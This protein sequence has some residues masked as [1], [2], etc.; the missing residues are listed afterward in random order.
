MLINYKDVENIK[1]NNTVEEYKKS[2]GDENYKLFAYLANEITN[3]T[4]IDITTDKLSSGAFANNINNK[5]YMFDILN[6]ISDNEK[7][8]LWPNNNVIYSNE[9]ITDD[10]IRDKFKDLILNSSII[11]IDYHPHNGIFEYNFYQWLKENNYKGLLIFDDIHYFKEMR[12]NLWHKIPSSEKYDVT[13]FG[14]WSGTGLV[15][16]NGQKIDLIEKIPERIPKFTGEHKN[17]TIVTAYFNLT[18]TPDASKEIIARDINHYMKNANMTMAID[19]NLVVYCDSESIDY[20]KSLRPEHLKDKTKYVTIE[21]MDVDIVKNNYQ[22]VVDAKKRTGYN[23]DP[24]MTTSYYLFC[25]AR[26]DLVLKTMN[27]NPFNST[28]FAWCNICI[29]RYSWKNEVYFP[30]IW[31]EFRDKFSTCY[32]DYQPKSLVIDNPHKYYEWGRCSM[33]SGFFTGNKYYFTEFCKEIIKAFDDMLQL[34]LGHADEQLFSIVY[35]RHPE[36]FEFYYGD[37]Q[38]MIINYGWIYDRATEPVRNIMTNLDK[39]NENFMVLK[40]VTN[41]WLQSHDLGCFTIDMPTYNY[42]KYLNMKA[43]R[44]C[45]T[46]F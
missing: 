28:H 31:Q 8:N 38:E 33:C 21:F 13:K 19:Q 6:C 4:I 24:R 40:D 18:K 36:L 3:G 37:Y 2:A 26:F 27:E 14:H 44:A 35:F 39:N 34:D 23:W 1:L 10:T 29:E 22:K 17:W 20:L 11:S 43:T 46:L 15:V 16:F 42:V 32:I 9:N 12:D 25:M 5:V 30:K 41:R 7:K 45:S